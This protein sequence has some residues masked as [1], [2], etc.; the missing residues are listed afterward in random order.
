MNKFYALGK[1][2]EEPKFDFLYNSA[3]TSITRFNFKLNNKSV[4]EAFGY[5]DIADYI[6]R[7]LNK[8]DIIMIEGKLRNYN[9]IKVEIE[10]IYKL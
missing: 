4:I 6:I 7:E 1:I 5:D 9:K 2:L 10:K 3:M 8:N